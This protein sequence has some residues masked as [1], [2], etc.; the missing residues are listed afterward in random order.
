M[1]IF[2]GAGV[3][4]STLLF[5]TI[6]LIVSFFDKTGRKQ[7]WLARTWGRSLLW[8]GGVTLTVEGLDRLPDDGVYVVTPNHLSYYDTPVLLSSLPLQFRF[9]AKRGLFSIP[10]LGTHLSRAGHIPVDLDDPRAGVK[11]MNAAATIIRE[12]AISVV[13]FPEG[14]RSPNGHLDEFKDGAAYIGIKSGATIVPTALCGTAEIL[15][16]GSAKIRGGHVS[17]KIGEPI[18]TSHMHIKER[19]ALTS[20]IRGQIVEMLGDRV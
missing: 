12:K 3:L 8:I 17:V 11:T 16:F 2:R 20:R 15:P 5:G 9:M 13:V 19:H 7:A 10:L 14:G 4:L 6:S 18:D 1:F